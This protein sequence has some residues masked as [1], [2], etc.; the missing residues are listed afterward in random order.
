ML[1]VD[2]MI[3]LNQQDCLNHLRNMN[4]VPLVFW[5]LSLAHHPWL[6][7]HAHFSQFYNFTVCK[8]FLSQTPQPTLFVLLVKACVIFQKDVS[9]F[10][11]D[12]FDH[13]C[14]SGSKAKSYTVSHQVAFLL[15]KKNE[16][17][18]PRSLWRIW[19]IYLW[20]MAKT[21]YSIHMYADGLTI[22]MFVFSSPQNESLCDF[23]HEVHHVAA[24]CVRPWR[25]KQTLALRK[26]LDLLRDF[27]LTLW[28]LPH[29]WKGK[30]LRL[31]SAALQNLTH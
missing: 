12:V 23:H 14:F 11:W 7:A 17:K 1:Y 16:Q 27:C 25:T 21:E 3:C 15:G 28:V 24:P 19:G 4:I 2:C 30:R 10:V 6:S 26:A 18:N 9:C 20:N 29:A 8:H 13:D 22:R 5:I 31:Q